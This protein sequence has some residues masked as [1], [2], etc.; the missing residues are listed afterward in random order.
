[1]E[2]IILS[3]ICSD[4]SDAILSVSIYVSEKLKGIVF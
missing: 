2:S 3:A 1:M 4:L